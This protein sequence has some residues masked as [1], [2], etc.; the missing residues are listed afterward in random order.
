MNKLKYF[1]IIF[2]LAVIIAG[3]FITL[4]PSYAYAEQAFKPWN[5]V[6]S[7]EYNG[8]TFRYDLSKRI[9]GIEDEADKR[10]FY[11]GFN[12]RKALADDLIAEGLPRVAVYEYMLPDF[13]RIVNHYTY[14]CRDKKDAQ[15]SFSASGFAYSQPQDGVSVDIDKL[16]DSMISS[17]GRHITIRLPLKIDK[18][19]TVSELKKFTVKKSSFTTVYY[20]S[21]ENRSHNIALAAK[22]INGLT[23]KPD[24]AFSFNETVGE[25]TE[26]NGYKSSKVIMDGSYT[27]GVGGGV[28]QVSTTLYNALLLA[29]FIPKA[30]QHSL[31][32]SYVMSG[33]DAMVAYGSADLTFVNNTSHCI[34]IKGETQ[35]KTLTFTI[36][37]EPNEYEIKRESVEE[38]QPFAVKEIVDGVKYPE[39][40]YVDQTKVI[41]NG[42]DGVK[43]KAYLNYYKDGSLIS[44]RLIRSCSY[45]KVDKVIARGALTRPD[46]PLL[47]NEISTALP[48]ER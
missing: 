42:S 30:S 29:G 14:V 16:F 13:K 39:L 41:T 10:G 38:R 34:Y 31:V 40:I 24:E 12:K 33:F 27:D 26:Q 32:S 36:Y 28:C 3:V 2:A 17:R 20:N 9:S 46:E 19:V 8:D 47:Q 4:S 23:I 45:K 15:V 5:V 25:R 48:L 43:A 6:V 44:T 22:A 37:G 1:T 21:S 7:I 18:A 35:G 11:S